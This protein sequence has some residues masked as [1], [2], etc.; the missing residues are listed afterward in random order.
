MTPRPPH[1]TVWTQQ[2]LID[3]LRTALC[4][5]VSSPPSNAWVIQ[6]REHDL[7]GVEPLVQSWLPQLEEA[8]LALVRE[9][10]RAVLG[11]VTVEVAPV[12]D[13]HRG[14]L[15][16]H[17]E[18]RVGAPAVPPL[19]APRRSSHDVPGRPRLLIPSG[20]TAPTGSMAAGGIEREIPLKA[21]RSVLGSGPDADVRLAVSGVVARHAELD[22]A[23][24]A[25]RITLHDLGTGVGTL[26]DGVRRETAA[27]H[28]GARLQLGEATLV[29]RVDPIPTAG[30]QGGGP[31]AGEGSQ[32]DAENDPEVSGD[33]TSG[34][35]LGAGPMIE[36]IRRTPTPLWIAVVMLVVGAVLLGLGIAFLNAS[37]VLAAVCGGFG[38]VV[39]LTGAVL[40]WRHRIFE[41][42]T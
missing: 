39:G 16:V 5:D 35:P 26:V 9:Q 32:Q 22:V 8:A 18:V 3:A 7:R 19:E 12:R 1:R 25:A 27:L 37:W 42:V 33:R 29:L 20:G 28:D 6:V 23:S 4:A 15:R 24:D 14:Q 17:G 36:G 31:Q 40:A 2:Q 41:D 38:L 11:V 21:G 10:A 30:R 34:S 13:L